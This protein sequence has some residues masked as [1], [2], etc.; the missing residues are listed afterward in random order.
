MKRGGWYGLPMKQRWKVTLKMLLTLDRAEYL[1][2]VLVF[3]SPL[4]QPPFAMALCWMERHGVLPDVLVTGM[5]DLLG[6]NKPVLPGGAP[7]FPE[8]PPAVVLFSIS[9]VVSACVQSVGAVMLMVRLH[10]RAMT[11]DPPWRRMAALFWG[12]VLV[13]AFT[14]F[15]AFHSRY[16][17]VQLFL[18]TFPG[19]VGGMAF[20]ALILDKMAEEAKAIAARPKAESDEG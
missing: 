15:V 10:R 14:L 13:G 6:L 4:A 1:A 2:A 8:L 20:L 7:P 16:S 5:P 12:P 17:G 18:M 3:L 11:G 9:L 19:S